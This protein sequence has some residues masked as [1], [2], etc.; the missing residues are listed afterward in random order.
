MNNRERRIYLSTVEIQHRPTPT[1]WLEAV[2]FVRVRCRRL[3]V[4]RVWRRQGPA[5]PSPFHPG[6]DLN[7]NRRRR[8]DK[9]RLS[10]SLPEVQQHGF[11]C[12]ALGRLVVCSFRLHPG[13][14]TPDAT[15]VFKPQ[16]K[17]REERINRLGLSSAREWAY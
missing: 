1:F 17:R 16:K 11:D 4:A 8:I 7:A 5:V 3:E 10:L 14:R 15:N 9:D 13:R 2:I 6:G 12:A